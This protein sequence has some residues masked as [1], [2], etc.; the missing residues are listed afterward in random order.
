MPLYSAIF[1]RVKYSVW[2][3]MFPC[4]PKNIAAIA[5]LPPLAR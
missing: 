1:I 4:S 3:G 5:C 2:A